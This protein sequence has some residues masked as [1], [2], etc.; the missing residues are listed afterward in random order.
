VTCIILAGPA[1]RSK[2]NHLLLTADTFVRTTLPGMKACSAIV[3]VRPGS[4]APDSRSTRPSSKPG[5]ELGDTAAQRFIFV[6]EG[7]VELEVEGTD[8]RARVAGGYAYLPAGVQLT[9]LWRLNGRARVAVIEK[10]YQPLPIRLRR[11]R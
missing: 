11:R 5:G 6:I 7:E 10:L 1:A 8:E 9:G 4:Q 3:H 2:P